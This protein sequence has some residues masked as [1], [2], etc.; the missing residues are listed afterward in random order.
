MPGFSYADAVKL[1]GAKESKLISALDK[2]LSGALLGGSVLG[3]PQLLGWFD[4]K[5]DFIRLSHEL[6]TKVSDR[7]RSG[8]WSA[9]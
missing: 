3:L 4:A 2:L 6:V 9:N 5:S 8:Y 1:L 7:K